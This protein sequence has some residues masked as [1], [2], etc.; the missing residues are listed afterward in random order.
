MIYKKVAKIM[1]NKIFLRIKIFKHLRNK[2]KRINK[3]INFYNLQFYRD[4]Q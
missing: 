4:S 1:Y 3:E 2:V